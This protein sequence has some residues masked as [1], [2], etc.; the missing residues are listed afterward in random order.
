M[1]DDDL[2]ILHFLLEHDAPTTAQIMAY[3]LDI[4]HGQIKKRLGVLSDHGMVKKPDEHPEGIS[5]RGVYVISEFGERYLSGD[6]T[7]SE[8]R[9]FDPDTGE[10]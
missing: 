2:T 10:K 4:K 5:G 6:L 1:V 8:F 7:I 3:E 9:E